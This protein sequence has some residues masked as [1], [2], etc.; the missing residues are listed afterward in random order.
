MEMTG[1]QI[2][3]EELKAGGVEI[4]FGIPGGAIMPFYDD[5]LKANF[6]HILTRHEQGAAHMADGYARVSGKV[7]VVVATSGPG[8]TNLITGLLTAQ[9]DSVPLIAVT[10]Q[11]ATPMIGTD[12][13]QEADIYGCSI[14]VT[15]YNWLV[16][17][18]RQ[19]Q[20]VIREA[21]RVATT[22]RPGPV[23]VDIP[24]DI[25]T[26]RTDYNPQAPAKGALPAVRQMPEADAKAIEKL[27]EALEQA[28]RPV[29]L[30]GAGIIKAGAA[31]ELARFARHAKIPVINTLL[32]MGGFPGTDPLFLGM[33][34]M[35]GTAYANFALCECDLL[36]S[37]GARFDDRVTGKVSS[38][39]PKAV[40]AHVDIDDAE[41]GKRVKTHIPVLG[42]VR[43]VLHTLNRQVKPTERRAWLDQVEAWKRDYPLQYGWDGSIKPQYVI[44]QIQEITGGEGIYATGVGQH[45][46]WAAQFLRFNEP[47][48]FIS[49]GGLGTMGYGLPASIGAKFG[50][51]DK[52]VW[53]IDGDGSFAMTLVELATASMYNVP[54]RV[55]ILNNAFLGMVRQ[56]QELFFGKR[57]SHSHYPTNPDF[58]KIAEG[59]GVKGFSVRDVDQVRSVLEQAAEHDGPVVM[60]FHVNP[61][62]NVWPMVPAGAGNDEMQLAPPSPEDA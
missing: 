59:Y 30:A 48:A 38:F 52:E 46:M 43:E 1:A 17:D 56:W 44:E 22:G 33:P 24:K 42:N 26:A 54:I 50:R 31:A 40:I 19:I 9:M 58:A 60:D 3:I 39:C 51:P 11:V 62:E 36:I 23:L 55:A 57:Y 18:A 35:H 21:I 12:A 13:F 14:P 34:G 7:A 25:Q 2:A 10:G 47:R 29:I 4:A 37:L 49:S 16:K 8:A 61:E 5:L 32:G 53:L 41:I 28:E 6:K 15:K 45:Q 27:M 20:G